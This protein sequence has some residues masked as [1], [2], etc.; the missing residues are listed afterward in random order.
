MNFGFQQARKPRL[1]PLPSLYTSDRFGGICP[2]VFNACIFS[3]SS[4]ASWRTMD[5]K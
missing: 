4:R 2:P 3:Q 1:Y 5:E